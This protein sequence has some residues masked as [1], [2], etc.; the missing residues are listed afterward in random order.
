[1]KIQMFIY[2]G[3]T[4]LDLIGP[5]QTW[6]QWPGAKFQLVAQSV[7]SIPTDCGL[8]VNAT[9]SFDEAWAHPDI[10]FVPGGTTGTFALMDN[11]DVLTF[12][13]Q[14][15]TNANWVTSVCTG[16]IV[17]AAAGLLTGYR[18]TSHWMAKDMLPAFGVEVAEGRWVIDRN[19]AS[20]GGVTA[21]IDF[22]LAL[23]AHISGDEKLAQQVQ[24]AMEYSPSPPFSSG[25]PEEAS[26]EILAAV[27]G[28]F[29]SEDIENRTELMLGAANRLQEFNSNRDSL[30]SMK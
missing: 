27:T 24:L 20:G 17:L 25:T 18:A 12:L 9:H 15:G 13:E 28:Y 11:E 23:M 8:S 30:E 16:S 21:G 7:G 1:M 5:L 19:R 29:N 4:L 22:G 10:L 26:P 3:M 6:S 14:R 2:P